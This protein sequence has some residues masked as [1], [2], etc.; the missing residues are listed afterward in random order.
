MWSYE[1][2]SLFLRNN[3]VKRTTSFYRATL[4]LSRHDICPYVRVRMSEVIS[5]RL[6]TS[7]RN[8][9]PRNVPASSAQVVLGKGAGVRGTKILHSCSQ[10]ACR[11]CNATENSSSVSGRSPIIVE[12]RSTASIR[13]VLG[14]SFL[15]SWVARRLEDSQTTLES[16]I[17]ICWRKFYTPSWKE[18]NGYWASEERKLTTDEYELH[19]EFIGLLKTSC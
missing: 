12:A 10:D 11:P 2:N 16:S 4:N 5:K 19:R 6:N 8:D 7:S 14:K 18:A 1:L 17:Y 15:S 9:C 3:S 13:N